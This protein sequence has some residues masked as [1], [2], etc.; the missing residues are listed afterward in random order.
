[1]R[2]GI[3]FGTTSII[4]AAVDRGNYPIVIFGGPDGHACDWFP[5]LIAVRGPECLYGWQAWHAQKDRQATV[6]CSI[7]RYLQCAGPETQVEIAGRKLVLLE[8]LTGLMSALRTA[9]IHDSS[10]QLSPGEPLEVMLGVPANAN[11]NQRFLTVEAF[12][13]AGFEVL[14]ML[15]EPSAASIE[16]SHSTRRTQN[17]TPQ[18]MLIYDLGG[19]TFDASLVEGDTHRHIVLASEGI[20]ALGGDD[21]D[22]VLAEIAL[23]MAGLGPA[24]HTSLSPADLFWLHDEC[25]QRKEAMH[26][27]T[28]SIGIDLDVLLPGWGAVSVPVDEFY[29]RSQ[30]LIDRTLYAVRRLLATCGESAV[31]VVYVTGGGSELPLV[32][33]ALRAEFG[34]RIRRSGYARSATAIGLAV[35]ADPASGY[36]LSDQITRTFGVWREAESGR[37]ITFD[38]LFVKGTE[39]PQRGEAPLCATRRYRPAHNVGHFRYLECGQL[40]E[41]DRPS[42]DVT[43][44]D[45]VLFPFEPALQSTTDPDSV[46]ITRCVSVSEHLIQESYSCDSAGRI[47]VQISNL[48]AGYVRTYELGRWAPE[49]KPVV[50]GKRHSSGE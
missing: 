44:W 3:D 7:K 11:A 49:S 31:D 22:D 10:V 28:R 19:G 35:Q 48:T 27:S 4:A 40:G 34:K 18:R 25:R 17:G 42:G 1:M 6:V 12:R 14:G 9:L 21:F 30:P 5:S 29:R 26:P 37:Q 23:E 32:W 15:N 45:E 13:R 38:P 36:W 50:L 43:L 16:F 2:L 39:L 47:T 41:S 20:P 33:Q 24:E 8:L 46:P